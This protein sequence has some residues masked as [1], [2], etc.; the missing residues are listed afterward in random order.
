M[1]TIVVM[2]IQILGYG[3]IK[4]VNKPTIKTRRGGR[5][6]PLLGKV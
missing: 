6:P 5:R 2:K 1:A 4:L 3:K